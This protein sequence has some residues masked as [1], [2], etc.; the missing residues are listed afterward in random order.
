MKN[1]LLT[2]IILTQGVAIVGYAAGWRRFQPVRDGAE[3]RSAAGFKARL[4]SRAAGEVGSFAPAAGGGQ[5]AQ[6]QG[7][8]TDFNSAVAQPAYPK[9]HPKILFDEAHNN[10]YPSRGRY[11][12]FADL[13]AA[14]G[15]GL[16]PNTRRLSRETLTG[17][18]VLVIVNAQGPSG[19]PGASPFAEQELD[20]I[21]DWVSKGGGLL[22]IT[23]HPPFSAAA[24]ALAKRFEVDITQGYTID[25][26]KY[27][28]ESE[29]QTELV[30]TREDGL[31][32]DHPIIRGRDAA[33][34]IK[35]I[36]TFTGTSL[37]GPPKSVALLRLSDAAMDVLPPD[38]KPSASPEDPLPEHKPTSAAG[39]CQGIALE[40]GLGRVVV[41]GDAA[42]LTAQVGFRGYRFGMNVSGVDNRQ[43]GLNVM[44]WLSGLLR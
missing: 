40:F 22:L 39:R 16:V 1:V 25:P 33:E 8:D 4:A 24:A 3:S 2:L 37:K 20:A 18:K 9:L 32:A 27:N 42:M 41:L 28:K 7:V 6:Q 12:P 44:H 15:Y 10:A 23:D 5:G 31:L 17:S 36:I 35:R 26:S 38:R 29:D 34:Q 14:D 43:L 11:K 19:Q 21:R 30:F 13:I